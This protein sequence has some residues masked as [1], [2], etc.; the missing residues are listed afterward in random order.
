MNKKVLQTL[1]SRVFAQ[2]RATAA[3]DGGYQEQQQ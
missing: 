3:A 1:N 2:M